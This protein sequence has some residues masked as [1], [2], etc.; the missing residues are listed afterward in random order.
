MYSSVFIFLVPNLFWPHGL[1][2]CIEILFLCIFTELRKAF[3]FSYVGNF[4]AL[5]S[6]ST[7]ILQLQESYSH[8]AIFLEEEIHEDSLILD[9]CDG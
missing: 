6:D 1:T 2:I 3:W 8:L 4:T 9:F 7:Q 5:R